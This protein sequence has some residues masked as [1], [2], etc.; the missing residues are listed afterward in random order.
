V[1]FEGIVGVRSIRVVDML[2]KERFFTI[3]EEG[4]TK[5][6]FEGLTQ[7]MYVVSVSSRDQEFSLK[8]VVK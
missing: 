7:G 5:A 1:D 3:P 8:L 2:G 6:R 4:Q